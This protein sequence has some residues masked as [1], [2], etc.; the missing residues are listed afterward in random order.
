MRNVLARVTGV[1]SADPRRPRSQRPRSIAIKGSLLLVAVITGCATVRPAPDVAA[2]DTPP[3]GAW[4]RVLERFVDEGGRVDFAGINQSVFDLDRYVAWIYA[5]GPNN[6]PRLFPTRADKLAYHINAYNALAMWNI[7]QAGIPD[8]LGA[9]GRFSFFWRDRIEVGGERMSLYRYENDVI[10]SFDEPRIHFALNCMTLGC[11]HLPREPF[12]AERLAAQLGRETRQFFAEGR[13]LR[14][15]HD[16]RTV[17][18]S[19]IL[20]WFEEDFLAHA[21]SLH[22]YINR[23]AP[24]TVPED[25]ALAFIPYNWTL[26]RQ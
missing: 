9:V 14:V 8:R 23:Y 1:A 16:E 26:A 2:P 5:V 11:P 12:R 22:A 24:V 18:V 7:L 15:N 19:Q 21:P 6:R 4:A 3:I 10:R 25:Y 20:D 17:Y 13:N